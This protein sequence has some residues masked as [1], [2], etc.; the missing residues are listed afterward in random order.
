MFFMTGEDA[1][2]DVRDRRSKEQW[3]K[4]ELKETNCRS[5]LSP[6]A[7]G[8]PAANAVRQPWKPNQHKRVK[9]FPDGWGFNFSDR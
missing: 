4:L 3:V 6:A 8:S 9:V 5:A 1:E 7:A 2:W